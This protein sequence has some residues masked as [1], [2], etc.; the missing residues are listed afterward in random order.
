MVSHLTNKYHMQS[1]NSTIFSIFPIP[2][3]K[4]D[5]YRKYTPEELEYIK[6]LDKE[7]NLGNQKSVDGY[8][9][10]HEPLNEIS[11]FCE[12]CVNDFYHSVYK[13]E[14]NN[15]RITQ[16]WLNYTEQ[17]EF[18]HKHMHPNSFISGVMY[19]QTDNEQ[20]K[21]YFFNGAKPIIK[22]YPTE[23]NVHNSDSW[24]FESITGQLL[25]FPSSLEHTVINRPDI[26][27]TR[28]S[29]SFNTFFTG[30]IGSNN[31][32]DELIF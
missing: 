11:S 6:N 8:V 20:D 23:F 1:I 9:L 28:I 13:P 12:T 32:L 19:I 15:I 25:L 27:Y 16:S 21:I 22:M 4:Y 5:F 18:H 14:D 30:K 31:S 26:D 24:Y 2:I 3:G 7:K 10:N 17:G 29:L